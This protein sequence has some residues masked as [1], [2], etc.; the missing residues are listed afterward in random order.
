MK[1]FLSAII[2][3]SLMLALMPANVSAAT[4]AIVYTE[5]EG[6]QQSLKPGDSFTYSVYISGTYDGFSVDI[7]TVQTGLTVTSVTPEPEIN[8]D[9][10]NNIWRI[11]VLGGLCRQNSP[12]TKIATITAK[13]TGSTATGTAEL[14]FSNIAVSNELGDRASF[15]ANLASV[16]FAANHPGTFAL[17]GVIPPAKQAV[18][19]GKDSILAPANITVT[20]LSWFPAV[21]G[22]FAADTVYT[23][24]LNVKSADG[25]AFANGVTFTVD[26]LIWT[27]EIQSDGSCN[28]VKTFPKTASSS[29]C[30]APS[31]ITAV[32]GQMLSDVILHNP[33]GNPAGTWSWLF[34]ATS[35]GDVGIKSFKAKFIPANPSDG[36][37]ADNVDISVSVMPKPISVSILP[38][39]DQTYTGT[40]IRPAVSVMGDGRILL[41]G[42][43]YTVGYGTNA[44]VGTNAGSVTVFAKAGSNYSFSSVTQYFHILAQPGQNPGG[45]TPGTD[46]PGGTTP[47]APAFTDVAPDTYYAQAVEWA[48]KNGITTGIS[49]TVFGPGMTCTRAQAVTFLWRAAGSPIP[50]RTTNS[51]KDVAPGTYYYNAVLWAVENG[52]TTG[53]SAD[54]FA[55]DAHCTRAQI[56]TFLYRAQK[57]PSAAGTVAFTDVVPGAYYENAVMWAVQNGITT[58]MSANTFAPNADCTR[59]QIVTFLYRTL[60]DEK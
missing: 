19:V 43:D 54:T 2:V 39:A 50:V 5:V 10:L 7:D 6:A 37:V 4:D 24:I 33:A 38:I 42:I 17:T 13:V 41:S 48:V 40:Q 36:A 16:S 18:P 3:F 58:G 1:K 27:A 49:D 15:A 11:S 45:G 23:A 53:M 25:S 56:V 59:A 46:I 28:L 9:N 47:A 34:P 52:I 20:S 22:T 32:Y 44:S 31:G 57:S 35:V 21:V 12:K 60:G 26:G 29:A 51:F 8:A 14:G 30:V 55:P